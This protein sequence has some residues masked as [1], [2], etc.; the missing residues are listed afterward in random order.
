L[1]RWKKEALSV[2]QRAEVEALAGALAQ[3]AAMIDR[4]IA[5]AEELSEGTIDKLLAKSDLQIGVEALLGRPGR[6]ERAELEAALTDEQR[7]TVARIDAR[8]QE[9]TRQGADD[10]AIFA[11]MGDLMPSFKP[12]IDLAAAQPETFDSL[13]RQF[14]GVYVYGKILESIAQGIAAGEIDVPQ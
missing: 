6:G 3:A 10:L 7:A 11:A 1:A 12:L 13:C 2:G 8:V 5:L 4:V 14:P 9:L